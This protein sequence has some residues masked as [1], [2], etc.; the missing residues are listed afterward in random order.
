M[1]RLPGYD[2]ST[3]K[4]EFTA[5]LSLGALA[6]ALISYTM[7]DSLKFANARDEVMAALEKP[8]RSEAGMLASH[9]NNSSARKSSSGV[10]QPLGGPAAN[11]KVMAP[12]S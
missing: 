4:L 8:V 2:Q 5:F 1:N 6:V 12:Q 7:L 9:T 11:T 3:R 10:K